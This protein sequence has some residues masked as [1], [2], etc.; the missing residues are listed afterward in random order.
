M[1]QRARQRQ[2]TYANI[3][4]NPAAADPTLHDQAVPLLPVD[5]PHSHAYQHVYNV[6]HHPWRVQ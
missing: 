1:G 2:L 3:Q 5:Q 6:W 4:T